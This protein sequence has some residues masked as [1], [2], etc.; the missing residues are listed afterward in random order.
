MN[1]QLEEN[2]KQAQASNQVKKTLSFGPKN[3]NLEIITDLVHPTEKLEGLVQYAKTPQLENLGQPSNSRLRDRQ[4][5]TT[6]NKS[7]IAKQRAAQNNS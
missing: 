2:K 3:L 4:S 5:K 1:Q 7:V 6:K